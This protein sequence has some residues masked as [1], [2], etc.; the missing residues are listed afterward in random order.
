M[1]QQSM[2]H[3]KYWGSATHE[4]CHKAN[5]PHDA[6]LKL[7]KKQYRKSVKRTKQS[8]MD[9]TAIHKLEKTMNLLNPTINDILFDDIKW[10]KHFRY[11]HKNPSYL[12]KQSTETFYEWY[13]NTA[14]THQIPKFKQRNSIALVPIT[15]SSSHFIDNDLI[16]CLGELIEI[17]FGLKIKAIDVSNTN[18]VLLPKKNNFN[19]FVTNDIHNKL[20][21]YYNND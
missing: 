12:E 13:C 8:K 6:Y 15:D 20:S 10:A 16:S 5:H 3:P 1:A 17:F 11:K 9:N 4:D 21:A 2:H 7:Y 14:S 18:N 19:N